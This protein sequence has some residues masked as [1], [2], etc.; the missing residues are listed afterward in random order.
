M[1]GRH[2]SG[3]LSGNESDLRPDN[4]RHGKTVM[5]SPCLLTEFL[6]EAI[7]FALGDSAVISRLHVD[8]DIW[9]VEYEPGQVRQMLVELAAKAGETMPEGAAIEVEAVN[10]SIGVNEV[11]QL[12]A[13]K[14]VRLS[15]K[16]RGASIP[17]G[18][19]PK[20]FDPYFS[21]GDQGTDKTV[22]LGLFWVY[23][24]ARRCGGRAGVDSEA[25]HGRVFHIY[26]PASAKMPEAYTDE[27]TKSPGARGRVLLMDDEDM[28][29]DMAGQMLNCIGYEAELV[30]AGGEAIERYKDSRRKGEPFDVVILDLTIRGGMGGKETIRTLMEMDPTVKVILSSG[31]TADR[32]VSHFKEYGFSALLPKP[33]TMQDLIRVLQEVMHKK[34]GD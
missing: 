7:Q 31:E 30:R 2:S 21:A 16:D 15:I 29:R 6:N 33:Y 9:T 22:G 32:A 19:L 18:Y 25:G 34:I 14:Y 3:V 11:P 23:S 5:K 27:K 12:K 1:H 28:I 13:G 20:I 26:L 10:R 17:E 4:P 24:I 8:E